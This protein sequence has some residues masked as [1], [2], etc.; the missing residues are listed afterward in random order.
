MSEQLHEFIYDIG[1]LK[2]K[3][4]SGWIRHGIQN[5]ESVAEH[6][7]RMG[8]MAFVI[9]PRYGLDPDKCLKM[10]I[11]HDLGESK[12]PDYTPFDNISKEDK[13]I[14]EEA[15]MRELCAKVGNGDDILSLWYE[16]EEGKTPE[17]IFVRGLDRL[18][19]LFQAEEYAQEQSTKDLELFWEMSSADQFGPVLDIYFALISVRTK[20]TR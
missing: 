8:I 7:F 2:R 19:M 15:A 13:F 5:P 18:E 12:I 10:A 4:R 14:E 1:K 6:S 3:D 11:F 20:P 9:A 17:A 16:F